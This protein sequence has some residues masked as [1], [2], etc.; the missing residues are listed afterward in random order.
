MTISKFPIMVFVYGTLR[1]GNYNHTVMKRAKG[2]YVGLGT[3]D[4]TMVNLGAYPA[5]VLKDGPSK[6]VGE[7]YEIA[8]QDLLNHLDRLEG[9]PWMYSR[10]EVPVNMP[11]FPDTKAWVY[12]MPN[13]MERH[14]QIIESGDW[15]VHKSARQGANKE[16]SNG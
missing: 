16:Q 1:T 2:K 8:N 15:E 4:A 12:H 3:I 9:Y 5:V 7:V 6:V 14:T 11:D 13:V 10:D